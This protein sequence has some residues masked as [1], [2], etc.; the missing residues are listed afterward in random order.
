MSPA[1]EVPAP[2]RIRDGLV[3]TIWAFIGAR[4]LLLVVSAIGVGLISM[5]E[6]QPVGV[7]GWPARDADRGW[8]AL[9]TATERQD[10]LWYLRIAT[11]GYDTD[12]GS[13][14]FFPVYPV[15][16]RAVA[17]LPGIGPLGAALLVANAAAFGALLML[18]A[19]TRREFDD[20]E[21][22]RRTVL[23]A[24]LFP[25]A[26]FL[27][28]PYTESLFLLLAVSAFWF[29]RRERWG[30]AALVGAGAA[31]TRG[32]GFVVAI[33][34][35]VEAIRQWRAEGRPALPRLA[36]AVAAG[37]APVLYL[38]AWALAHD[39][40]T[41]PLDAQEGWSRE[42]WSPALTLWRA[43]T[44]AW[45]YQTWWLIDVVVVAV[46]LVGL[47]AVLRHAVAAYS[48]FAW[49]GLMVPLAL[50]F[51]DRPLLSAP[52]FVM[53]LFPAMWGLARLGGRR[54][55]VETALVAGFAAG[56]ALLATLFVNWQPIF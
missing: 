25:T 4:I 41:A 21:M 27:L 47:A 48:V 43:L 17:W 26:F 15:A 42:A 35:L 46:V 16:V 30:W 13:A 2:P 6:G 1:E 49:A 5:P 45:R 39:D 7:P 56:Y 14:A 3:Q 38:G 53:V 11:A 24:A 52:R 23:L 28:A 36:G 19:L 12:D 55:G 51:P 32:I 37:S 31:L 9:V 44:L 18:H 34:L 8:G 20:P 40:P 29:A 54:R 50:P 22:A 33:G 10:A